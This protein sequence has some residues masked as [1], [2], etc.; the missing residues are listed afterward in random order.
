[1]NVYEAHPVLNSPDHARFIQCGSPNDADSFSR[2]VMVICETINMCCNSCVM[3]AYGAMRR[4]KEI[5]PLSLFAKVL[6]DYREMGGGFLSLTPVTGEVFLDNRLLDRLALVEDYPAIRGVSFTTNAV[7]SDLLSDHDLRQVMA[8]TLKVQI[9]VYGIDASE[10][11][12]LT[13]KDAFPR[14]MRSIRRLID[15]TEDLSRLSIGFRL[16]GPRSDDE[17]RDWMDRQLGVVLPFGAGSE[18]CDWHKASVRCEDDDIR[19]YRDDSGRTSQC[20]FPMVVSQ[21]F[22]NGDVAFCKHHADIPDEHLLGNVCGQSLR[23]IFNSPKNRRL[24]RF[25]E[26]VP[27]TCAACMKNSYWYRPESDLRAYENV[28]FENPLGLIGA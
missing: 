13:R 19:W 24:W 1:M 5:M 23:D 4:K 12:R 28:F 16:V 3:C 9:S 7:P 6:N 25:D 15:L 8:K 2:P 21:V 20:F 17:L 11:F 27:E 18:Y 22:V 10:H 14:A 26:H